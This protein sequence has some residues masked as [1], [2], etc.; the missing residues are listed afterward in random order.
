MN[1]RL[2]A[3]DMDGTLLDS[4]K[5][6]PVDFMDWV[7]NH[8]D[9]KT[10][11]ASGRQYYT[12]VKDFLPIKERLIYVAENGGFVFEDDK[13]LFK[14]VMKTEDVS[15]CLKLI[16]GIEGLTPVLC[17]EASAYMR[18]SKEH[19]LREV[20]MYYARLQITQDLETAAHSDSITK[21]AIFVDEKKAE[22]ATVHFSGI[23]HHLA[24]VL[25]GDSWIDISNRTVNKGAAVGVILQKYGIQKEEAMA[26]G[27]Y[28]NDAQLLQSCG[29][30]Y[31]MENGH[32]DLKALAKHMADS[33]DNDGVMRVLRGIS[34]G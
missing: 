9:I 12:L 17:G 25:S 30:S 2:V 5:R 32:P 16:D 4:Q 31:C 20:E 13:I 10:V 34:H 6:L 26:F 3:M 1:I 11:I 8:P 18:K 19:V 14:N 7:I 24:A 28:L 27:D 33:N 15:D 29:E 21:I 23:K 22:A